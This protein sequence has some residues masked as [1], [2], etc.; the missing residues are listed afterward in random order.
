MILDGV[1]TLQ[2]STVPAQAGVVKVRHGVQTDAVEDSAISV[3]EIRLVLVEQV[4][5]ADEPVVFP[6]FWRIL[7]KLGFLLFVRRE[8]EIPKFGIVPVVGNAGHGTG[9]IGI[10]IDVKPAVTPGQVFTHAEAQSICTSDITPG[11]H[12]IFLRTIIDCVPAV[13]TRIPAIEVIAVDAERHEVF[14]ACL[15]VFADE[16]LG[17]PVF[18]LLERNDILVAKLGWMSEMLEVKFV[19]ARALYVHIAGVPITLPRSRLRPPVRPNAEFHIVKPIGALI[20]AQRI[21]VWLKRSCFV[22]ASAAAPAPSK[23]SAVRLVSLFEGISTLLPAG[24]AA[25][26][27]FHR[28]LFDLRGRRWS[29]KP[30]SSETM[31]PFRMAEHPLWRGDRGSAANRRRSGFL[32]RNAECAIPRSIVAEIVSKPIRIR[33]VVNQSCSGSTEGGAMNAKA[34][35]ALVSVAIFSF[36]FH[37]VA[38]GQQS[39]A[40]V[41]G[42]LITPKNVNLLYPLDS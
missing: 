42:T 26:L 14:G 36:L 4:A 13:I 34:G 38:F 11:C 5:D 2:I 28:V 12:D 6:E 31:V 15:L 37:S 3:D 30:R 39:T 19:L 20:L 35:V 25:V 16:R 7:C 8:I 22:R 23:H 1:H 33:P 18:R 27:Q 9:L 41:R 17:F 24:A 40:S 32:F 29:Q 21:P 10:L